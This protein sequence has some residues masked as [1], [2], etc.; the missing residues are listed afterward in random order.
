MTIEP[1]RTVDNAAL[2]LPRGRIRRGLAIFWRALGRNWGRDVM[3]YTGGVSFY[4]LLAVFP[5]LSI[6][7]SVYAVLST[8]EA[9]AEQASA[10]AELMPAGAE[11][12]L[13]GELQRL[14]AA[15]A[16]VLSLQGAL[17][18]IITAYAAH[19]GFKA[20]LAGLTFI[21]EEENPHG[22]VSFNLLAVFAALA[23]FAL[24]IVTSTAF[25]TFRLVAAAFNIE[26]PLLFSEWIWASFGLTGGLTLLYRYGMS[27]ARTPWLPSLIGGAVGA[28]LGLFVSWLCAVYVESI[29]PLGATYGSVGAVV[30]FLIWISWNTNAVFVGGALA[31]EIEHAMAEP[32]LL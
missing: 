10:F 21:H 26:L 12:L 14:V 24:L 20:L 29:A 25:F 17:A 31:T 15:P 8:P 18:F 22:F 23:A 30:V 2:R 7:I 5:A 6:L 3:L 13:R 4:G 9:A 32:E 27:R 19:R 11:T 16:E 1:S 28:V